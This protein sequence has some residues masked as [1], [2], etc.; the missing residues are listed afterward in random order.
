M[1]DISGLIIRVVHIVCGAF[2]VG[3]AIMVAGFIEPAVA[4]LGSDGGKFMHRLMGPGR[5]GVFMTLAGGLTALTGISM[6]WL[7][8]GTGL[9]SWLETGYGRSILAGSVAGVIG[10]VWGL[11]VNA[12]TAA[13]LAR[14]GAELPAA[15]SPPPAAQVAEVSRL[16]RRLHAGGLVSVILLAISIVAMAAAHYL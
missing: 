15:G 5:F 12:P 11:S 2:W 16:Q 1:S 7:N 14:L 13:R 8:S 3:A 9:S 4:A 6:L 10:L